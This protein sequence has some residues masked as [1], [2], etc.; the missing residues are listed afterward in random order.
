M[1]VNHKDCVTYKE[2]KRSV[3][4]G[5]Y[6]AGK[7]SQKQLHSDRVKKWQVWAS[8]EGEVGSLLYSGV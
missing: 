8:G 1:H 4:D 2:R 6:F 5:A 7:E 3:N